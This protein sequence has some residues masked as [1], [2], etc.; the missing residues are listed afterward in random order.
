M[1]TTLIKLLYPVPAII[2]RPVAQGLCDGFDVSVDYTK[3]LPA[4]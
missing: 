4:S 3:I 2:T 1:P